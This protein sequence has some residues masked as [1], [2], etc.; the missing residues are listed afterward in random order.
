MQFGFQIMGDDNLT[1]PRRQFKFLKNVLK[2]LKG[3]WKFILMVESGEGLM[4]SRL[5]PL[6]RT[7]FS[8][9]DL[10]FMG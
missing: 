3:I 4:F 6:V 9:G 10:Y 1:P 7:M 8:S 5:S 2:Q